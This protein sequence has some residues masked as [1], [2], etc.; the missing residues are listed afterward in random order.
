MDALL[1]QKAEIQQ[2]LVMTS[3]NLE[4]TKQQAK[5]HTHKKKSNFS[6]GMLIMTPYHTFIFYL[7]RMM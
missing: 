4:K 6:S 5:V 3:K 7:H 2:S 1:L